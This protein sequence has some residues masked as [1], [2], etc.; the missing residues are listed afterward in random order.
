MD[1]IKTHALIYQI[2]ALLKLLGIWHGEED[3]QFKK[4]AKTIITVTVCMSFTMSLAFGA[5]LSDNRNEVIFLAAA[6]IA[7]ALM[8][9]KLT[10]VLW[11]KEE[12]MEFLNKISVYSLA[13]RAQ[14]DEI[15]KKLN[16][17]ARLGYISIITLS[18][19]ILIFIVLSLPIFS[20]E[21]RLPLNVAF[22]LD[23][24]NSTLFYC[25][26]YTF[27]L[28]GV[29]YAMVVTFFTIVYLYIMINC[30]VKYQVL[31]NEFRNLNATAIIIQ[32]G[33]L[34][35]MQEKSNLQTL[36]QLIK[37]HQKLYELSSSDGLS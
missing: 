28:T 15:N 14:F 5:V 22:P 6:S 10:Y 25:L 27:V 24:K 8:N 13:R 7:S 19:S 34:I 26:G 23:W 17:F 16:K 31:A 37:V 18:L 3:S 21:R 11:K 4:L 33:A 30:S 12:I 29:I 32:S 36:I 35:K 9:V 2:I 20:T 1:G